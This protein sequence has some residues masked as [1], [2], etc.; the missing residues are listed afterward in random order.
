MPRK[1]TIR[2]PSA[3]SLKE[4]PEVDFENAK[5]RRNP[6]AEK[7]AKTGIEIVVPGEKTKKITIR[8]GKGRPE[9]SKVM[10]VGWCFTSSLSLTDFSKK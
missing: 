4:M 1:K 10:V 5:I 2:E 6:Y 9:K 3:S 8:S 7:I